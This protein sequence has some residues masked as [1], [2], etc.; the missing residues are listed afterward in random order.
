MG[1]LVDNGPIHCV[2]VADA[3]LLALELSVL[4]GPDPSSRATGRQCR[5]PPAAGD[6]SG[7]FAPDRAVSGGRG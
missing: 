5:R 2:E 6:R 1:F 3:A 7:R 4:A